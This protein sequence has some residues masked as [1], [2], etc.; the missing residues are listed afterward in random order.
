MGTGT[1]ACTKKVCRIL[2]FEHASWGQ[3]CSEK[4]RSWCCCAQQVVW[5][6][7]SMI[8]LSGK[9]VVSQTLHPDCDSTFA[10]N[11]DKIWYAT[12]CGRA[13]CMGMLVCVLLNPAKYLAQFVKTSRSWNSFDT[14]ACAHTHAQMYTIFHQ[15]ICAS[16]DFIRSVW[17]GADVC[18]MA[19][20]FTLNWV[21]ISG[22]EN[23]HWMTLLYCR[24]L[25][26][27]EGYTSQGHGTFQE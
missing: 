11:F 7:S 21:G 14:Y 18:F 2:I 12:A 4:A 5:D 10:W 13:Q 25:N 9:H 1:K 20:A 23:L 27:A 8:L 3:L 24:P 22:M 19:K 6:A 26:V 16:G 15:A 17:C